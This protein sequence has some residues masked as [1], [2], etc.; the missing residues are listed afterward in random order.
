MSEQ[1]YKKIVGWTRLNNPVYLEN[2]RTG[3]GK[4]YRM[5]MIK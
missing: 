3:L 4:D 1:D 5:D 2:V